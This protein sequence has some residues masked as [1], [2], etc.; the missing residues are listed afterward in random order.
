M[1]K[2][3]MMLF[4]IISMFIFNVD[5]TSASG[6]E[7]KLGY[8]STGGSYV[9]YYYTDQSDVTVTLNVTSASG[10]AN[11]PMVKEDGVYVTL[12][13]ASL[14]DTYNYTVCKTGATCV[15]VIDPFSP[16][17]TNSGNSNIILDVSSLD[18]E[19][20]GIK[21]I[22]VGEMSKSI[23]ALNPEKYVENLADPVIEGKTNFS[24][25]DKMSASISSG[26]TAFGID[27]LK[28]AGFT[29]IEMS[30]LYNSNYYSNINHLYSNQSA[31]LDALSE[32]QAMMKLYKG[33]KLN[34]VLKT[35]FVNVS[36]ELEKNLNSMSPTAVVDGKLNFSN[37][38]AKRYIR[39][40]YARWAEE[41]YIDGFYIE[42]SNLYEDEFLKDLIDELIELDGSLFIYTNS[43]I[44]GSTVS[45]TLQNLLFGSLEELDG[46]GIVNGVYTSEGMTNLYKAMFGGYY[47]SREGYK[48]ASKVINNFGSEKGLDIYSKVKGTQGLSSND[49]EVINRIKVGLYTIYSSIGIPRIIAGNEFMNTNMN[50]G[51]GVESE[52]KACV[53]TTVC[54]LKG[55]YKSINWNSL[56]SNGNISAVM[57]T[58]RSM[59]YY[60][61]P[62]TYTFENAASFAV[63]NELLSSG[64]L[65]MTF[66]YNARSNGDM[67]RSLLIINY[68]DE[69]I[70]TGKISEKHYQS[71]SA[72]VGNVIAGEETT[73][74]APF[75]FYTY[76]EIRNLTLPQWV[77]IVVAIALV[78]LVVGVRQ[79]GIYMLKK[80]RGID[81][82]DI[83]PESGWLFR[84]NKGEKKNVSLE[85]D[86]I[87]ES[88]L[89]SDPLV[90]EKREQMK[91]QKKKNKEEKKNSNENNKSDENKND[92]SDNKKEGK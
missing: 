68:S 4:A 59:Y 74:F 88:F 83:K 42:D 15:D 44:G 31:E 81:Y 52:L 46:N 79:F 47:D 45:D 36:S 11:L 75:T 57:A 92:D 53:T 37:D 6:Y 60:Q 43:A 58:Y 35:N 49:Y 10:T 56:K 32:Y 12:Y 66:S 62:S 13:S 2:Y 23:Y 19:W 72:L 40:V 87:I 51:S 9:F 17:L 86:S 29:Y 78:G 30:N 28:T 20:V 5:I 50:D 67:S 85:E 61:F 21:T 54:Y 8:E 73:T 26:N 38:I 65:Y 48:N 33:Y 76:T 91:A 41:Y 69:S 90:K 70:E 7:G 14:G 77:Y 25:F 27:Y 80:K 1:K 22:S 89:M 55:E 84:K 18:A 34:V 71:V 39:E 64:I 63:N 82:N 3:L 24:V 16:Y